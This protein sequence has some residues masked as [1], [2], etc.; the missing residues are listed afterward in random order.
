MNRLCIV[1][2]SASL[3]F[4]CSETSSNGDMSMG[5]SATDP[6]NFD[7]SVTQLPDSV[8]VD[9]RSYFPVVPGAQWRY[10][11]QTDDWMT[12]PN[13]NERAVSTLTPGDGE[14][15]YLRSTT[16]FLDIDIDGESQLVRQVFEETFLI[17]PANMNVG[18]VLKIKSVKIKEFL[19]SDDTFLNQIERD[20]LPPYTLM[21]DAWRT[22]SFSTN[23]IEDHS[24]TET[25]TRAGEDEPRV[26]QSNLSIQVVT[27]VDPQVILMEG[28]YREG[29]RQIDVSDSL[30]GTKNRTYWVQQGVGIVQWQFQ[31]TNNQVFTLIDASVE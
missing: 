17:E 16:A 8:V 29:I 26:T 11:K 18:P 22:G 12:P 21:A 20:Y 7:S 13:A 3:L 6:L 5:D 31:P 28:Q 23:T 1:T 2:L 30:L 25:L 10:R 15:E 24:M 4:A 9:T 14:N 27:S 19:A